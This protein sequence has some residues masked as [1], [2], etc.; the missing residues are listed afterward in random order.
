MV[1]NGRKRDYKV[2]MRHAQEARKNDGRK[3]QQR[4]DRRKKAKL[5]QQIR[6]KS[7]SEKKFNTT[8]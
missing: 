1:D 6:G 2:R 7:R 5:G 8:G 4:E 3:N